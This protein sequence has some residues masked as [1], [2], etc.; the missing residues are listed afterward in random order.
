MSLNN[1]AIRLGEVG[2]RE[3]AVPVAEEA[4]ALYRALAGRHPDAFGPNLT[5]SLRTLA[6][7]LRDVGRDVAAAVVDAEAAGAC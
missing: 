7:R 6:A 3:E 5:I 4:V 2:R 1:L